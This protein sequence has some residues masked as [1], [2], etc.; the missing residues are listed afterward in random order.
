MGLV[1]EFISNYGTACIIIFGLVVAFLLL[2]NG[3]ALSNQKGRLE[4]VL[5]RKNYIYT[6]NADSKEMEEN[7]DESATIT[8]D[9]IRK[10]ETE[11]NEKCSWHGVLIQCIPVF[12]LLGIL[13]TVAGL[14]L[15]LQAGDIN[16][17]MQSLDVALETTFWGLIFAI[18]LKVIE[19]VFPARIISDVEVL[20]D[21]FDKKLNIAE[22]FRKFKEE[23]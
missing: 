14:M 12:P 7:E 18:I 22:M 19:A 13:G 2:R 23:K 8:P 16:A 15:E 11:F 1:L 4:D 17:M 6:L 10:Y 5:K 9:T 21:D 3:I 20:L